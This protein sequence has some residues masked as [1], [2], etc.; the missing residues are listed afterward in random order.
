MTVAS[1]NFFYLNPSLR[2]FLSS[3]NSVYVISNITKRIRSAD[4]FIHILCA[5][6]K[7]CEVWSMS[8]HKFKDTVDSLN[9]RS[10]N[11]SMIFPINAD[12]PNERQVFT[13]ELCGNEYSWLCSLR[14]HQLQC[15]NKEAKINCNFCAKKFYRRDRLKEHL[16]VYHFNLSP[17]CD[18][19]TK[20]L[21]RK[22]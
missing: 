17:E 16:F 2:F 9:V 5:G 7:M 13:C 1:I 20:V 10:F 18:K 19:P 21:T 14:R 11:N 3:E 8:S 22:E 15:G 12:D 6:P 4:F